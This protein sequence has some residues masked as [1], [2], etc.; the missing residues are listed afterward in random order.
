MSSDVHSVNFRNLS[1][2]FLTDPCSKSGINVPK[3]KERKK[4]NAHLFNREVKRVI[5]KSKMPLTFA[6]NPTL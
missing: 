1:L 2:I 5:Q 3:K 6:V 4:G